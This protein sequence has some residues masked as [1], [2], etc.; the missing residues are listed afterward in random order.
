MGYE[1]PGIS[2]LVTVQGMEPG[3]FPS[4]KE[5]VSGTP[6]IFQTCGERA[7][8]DGEGRGQR[9]MS[10]SCSWSLGALQQDYNGRPRVPSVTARVACSGTRLGSVRMLVEVLSWRREFRTVG[11]RAGRE[12]YWSSQ[13]SEVWRRLCKLAVDTIPLKD[14]N[15]GRMRMLN[16]IWSQ[17]AHQWSR[18]HPTTSHRTMTPD[19]SQ[20]QERLSLSNPEPCGEPL[21]P[22]TPSHQGYSTLSQPLPLVPPGPSVCI[23]E[24]HTS[25]V[26]QGLEYWSDG[27]GP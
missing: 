17:G 8:Q 23:S 18:Q 13:A 7:S 10:T 1:S 16:W 6:G 3:S 20:G 19:P 26:S 21:Y 25:R 22:P 11:R 27:I 9:G 15:K 4:P 24:S 12:Q 5:V 2:A 14:S